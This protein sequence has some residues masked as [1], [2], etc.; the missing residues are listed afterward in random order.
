MLGRDDLAAI[1]IFST[2][3]KGAA[4][5]GDYSDLA[6]KG[7]YN[8]TTL[9]MGG[10]H[11]AMFRISESDLSIEGLESIFENWLGY[12]MVESFGGNERHF[13][14]HSMRLVIGSTVLSVSMDDLANQVNFYYKTDA[15]ASFALT[16]VAENEDSKAIFGDKKQI[17][18]PSEYMPAAVATGKRDA[19]LTDHAFPF[20]SAMAM[21]SGKGR[22]TALEI[23]FRGYIHE[24][25]YNWYNSTSTS[26]TARST[27][28]SDIISLAANISTG[29]IESQLIVVSPESDGWITRLKRLD[30]VVKDTGSRYYVAKGRQFYYETIDASERFYTRREFDDTDH[31]YRNGQRVPPALVEPGRVVW[32]EDLFPGRA[33]D[34]V[35][36]RD[37]RARYLSKITYS[38]NGVR[39]TGG[40]S[41]TRQKQKS[42]LALSFSRAVGDV[43]LSRNSITRL[44]K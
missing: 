13:F 35:L 16:A 38:L 25:G 42:D 4:P 22:G 6:W 39:Q 41:P 19:Y 44:T 29:D 15:A 3:A 14:V 30:N 23:R 40:N 24:V 1:N 7:G 31:L 28:V 33:T 18:T 34:A 8:R 2:L 20:F 10:E 17:V 43:K 11:E 12:H 21:S 9:A 36:L 27:H 5:I 37:P 26:T 32:T